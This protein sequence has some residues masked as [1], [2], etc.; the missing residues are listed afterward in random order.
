MSRRA[1]SLFTML[2]LAGATAVVAAT[3]LV[4]APRFTG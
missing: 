4:V 3:P 1:F 2:A